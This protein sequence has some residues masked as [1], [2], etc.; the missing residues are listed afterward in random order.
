M[1]ESRDIH[2]WFSFKSTVLQIQFEAIRPDLH[3]ACV[4]PSTKVNFTFQRNS[5]KSEVI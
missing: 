1:E 2:V 4:D 3:V 5:D